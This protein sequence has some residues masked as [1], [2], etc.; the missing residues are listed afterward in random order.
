MMPVKK[1]IKSLARA[2]IM[3]GLAVNFN[4]CSEQSPMSSHGGEATNKKELKILHIGNQDRPQ[5]LN[6]IVSDSDLVTVQDGGNLFL[7]AGAFENQSFIQPVG[8]AYFSSELSSYGRYASNTINN[9]GMFDNP[10]AATSNHN[11]E[12]E[13]MWITSGST[14]G[15]IA[16]DLGDNYNLTETFIWNY[17][18]TSQGKTARGVKDVEIY[19]SSDSIYSSANF[20]N[21]GD[22]L[23][24]EGGTFA[25]NFSTITCNVRLVKF[26]INSNHGFPSYVGLSE[27]RFGGS[28]V[29]AGGGV[30]VN[31]QVLPGAV[32]ED[33]DISIS[34]DDELL[35]GDVYLTFGPHGTAFNPPAILDIDAFGLDLSGIDPEDLNVFYDNAETGQWELMQ[36]TEILINQAEGYIKVVGALLP[37]FSR[38]AIGAE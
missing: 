14:T 18:E 3:T 37:H 34:T 1:I 32:V 26:K 13:D 19:V 22:I 30:I 5:S 7:Q 17:N 8:I 28:P 16:F 24:N 21:I 20:T 12:R 11:V 2:A 35:M 23:V 27:V 29:S 33:V 31:F 10:S 25:Q 36:S 9:S 15:V 6:K 38:Y 4:A